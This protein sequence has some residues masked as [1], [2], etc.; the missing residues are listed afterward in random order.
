MDVLTLRDL[1]IEALLPVGVDITD[2]EPATDPSGRIRRT[3]IVGATPGTASGRRAAGGSVNRDGTL[4]VLVVTPSRD[5]CLALT[6]KT[7][8]LLSDFP[9]PGGGRLTDASYDGE[10][11]PEP[12]TSP[13]RWSK[14]LAF[15]AT[16][17]RG[18]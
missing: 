14:A 3:V 11:T 18:S 17:K 7:R 4:A 1:V 5:S 12:D 13:A 6:E 2:G 16:R 15:T 8:D 9:I 10:P